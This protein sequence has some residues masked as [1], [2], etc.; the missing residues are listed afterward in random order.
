MSLSNLEL[1][2]DFL[3]QMEDAVEN[4]IARYEAVD[5]ADMVEL[6]EMRKEVLEAKKAVQNRLANEALSS[7]ERSIIPPIRKE[8]ETER[9]LV[10]SG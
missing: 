9:R 10:S 6:Y 7:P 8:A 3:E 5:D 4:A 1:H 2:I